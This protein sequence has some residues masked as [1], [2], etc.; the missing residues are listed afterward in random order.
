MN[1]DPRSL[2]SARGAVIDAAVGEHRTV[3]VDLVPAEV[4]NLSSQGRP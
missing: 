2:V 1:G 4:A 3:E